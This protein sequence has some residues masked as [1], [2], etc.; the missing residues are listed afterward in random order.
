MEAF[1]LDVFTRGY[2]LGLLTKSHCVDLIPKENL[3]NTLKDFLWQILFETFIAV[4][5][6]TSLKVTFDRLVVLFG[7]LK[8]IVSLRSYLF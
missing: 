8:Q 4:D 1:H 7:F 5:E 2:L 6:L 3:S